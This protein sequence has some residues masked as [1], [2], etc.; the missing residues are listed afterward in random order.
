MRKLFSSKGKRKVNKH[1]GTD[2]NRSPVSRLRKYIIPACII[3]VCAGLIGAGLWWIFIYESEDAAAR[4]EYDE[5]REIFM[6]PPEPVEQPSD[7]I[8]Q[9]PEEE[10][11]EEDSGI[12]EEEAE[13]V[14]RLS[15]DEL[16]R[17]NPDLTGWISIEDHIEYPV[18]RGTN[19][20][21]Y[22]SI[23]FSGERNRAGAIFMDFRN[24]NGFDD[25]I[26]ILFGHRTRDG[27]M[28]SPLVN[29]LD[30]SFLQENPIITITTRDGEELTYR[31]F[32]ARLTDAWDTSYELSF[33]NP[34]RAA[35]SFPN[36]PP[37]AS[38]FLLLS[39]CTPSSDRDERIIVFAA[40]EE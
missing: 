26:A 33:S 15:M 32:S 4:N 7:N 27:T 21:R 9:E 20:D 36:V 5:L 22:M 17:I 2:K 35:S 31:I 3:T 12:I 13:I 23:T 28:F 10:I 40:L 8:E 39:T 14:E 19:N 34:D 16:A 24:R 11:E 38:R 37:G 30:R 29:Y 18:V 25:K 1:G 6:S